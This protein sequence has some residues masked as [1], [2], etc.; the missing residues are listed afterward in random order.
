[1]EALKNIEEEINKTQVIVPAGGRAKRMGKI[2]KPKALLELNGKTLLDYSIEFLV[3]CGFK[4]FVFLLGYKHEQIEEYVGDGS[5]YGIK[6]VFSVEPE[7]IKGR[8]KALKYA[9]INNKIDKTKRG[10]ICYPDDL[11]LDKNLPIKFLLHHL[12]GVEN[13]KTLVTSLFVSGTNYPYGV[14]DIDSEQLVKKFIEKP[15]IQKYTSTGLNIIEPEVY[16]E[17]EEKIDLNSKENP[18]FEQIILPDLAERNKVFSMILP[19]SVWLP[20]N[21]FKEQEAAEKILNNNNLC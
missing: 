18:E 8:A 16:R 10:L 5:K 11:Y 12:H 9:L 4:N 6:V 1:M 13:K 7:N 21:T 15:F 14:A 20:I 2:D 19:S 17:I 3:N